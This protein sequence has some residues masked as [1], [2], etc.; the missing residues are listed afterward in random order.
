L[1]Y[2]KKITSKAKTPEVN[3]KYQNINFYKRQ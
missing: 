1:N 3:Q 2:Y